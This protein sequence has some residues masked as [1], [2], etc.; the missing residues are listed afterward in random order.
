MHKANIYPRLQ[1]GLSK[2]SYQKSS[3]LL[4]QSSEREWVFLSGTHVF[5]WKI[6]LKLQRVS[7]SP[8]EAQIPR[9]YEEEAL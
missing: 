4:R 2:C 7:T 3:F 1:G 9:D 6:M 8:K 5:A